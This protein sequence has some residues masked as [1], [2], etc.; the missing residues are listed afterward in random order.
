MKRANL[1]SLLLFWSPAALI[2]TC[3]LVRVPILTLLSGRFRTLN[4]L[5][6]E[7]G[8]SDAI[9]LLGGTLDHQRAAAALDT[10]SDSLERANEVLSSSLSYSSFTS[11]VM[12]VPPA[13]II[14]E[15]LLRRND[16]A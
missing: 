8:R 11:I 13:L 16:A 15:R 9:S 10:C 7:H 2:L 12:L 4:E 6:I 1:R 5:V 14:V 3:G